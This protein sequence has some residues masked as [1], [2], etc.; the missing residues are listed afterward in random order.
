MERNWWENL[1]H[2][3]WRRPQ[4]W[5]E[6]VEHS[7][8]KQVLLSPCFPGQVTCPRLHRLRFKPGSPTPDPFPLITVL[9]FVDLN[10]QSCFPW[11][12]F[13]WTQSFFALKTDSPFSPDLLL[14]SFPC[15]GPFALGLPLG[16]FIVNQH[17]CLRTVV[18]K[19]RVAKWKWITCLF[20][21][22][23]SLPRDR[24]ETIALNGF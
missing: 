15:L 18:E 21:K 6:M 12:Y 4:C 14:S 17:F 5:W 16:R 20:I 9:E 22:N 24:V 10:Y 13:L 3:G 23:I 7:A 1:R 8:L 11:K 2:G 19:R